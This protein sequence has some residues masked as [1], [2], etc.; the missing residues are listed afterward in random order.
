LRRHIQQGSHSWLVPE[1]YGKSVKRYDFDDAVGKGA[2]RF[3]RHVASNAGHP[4]EIPRKMQRRDLPI[5]RRRRDAA[6]EP[7]RAQQIEVW[8]WFA[9]VA[10]EMSFIVQP[11]R[12]THQLEIGDLLIVMKLKTGKQC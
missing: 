9:L 2:Y 1:G 10:D 12:A 7:S 3:R 5:T 6:A 4:H 11:L 8:L